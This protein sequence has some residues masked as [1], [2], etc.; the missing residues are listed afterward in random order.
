M[1]SITMDHPSTLFI[2]ILY[3]QFLGSAT[4]A[5]SGIVH[6]W[7][8]WINIAASTGCRSAYTRKGRTVSIVAQFNVFICCWGLFTFVLTVMLETSFLY[9][10]LKIGCGKYKYC[11]VCYTVPVKPLSLLH[12]RLSQSLNTVFTMWSHHRRGKCHLHMEKKHNKK[13]RLQ[14][15]V[16][17]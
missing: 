9:P 13:K 12:M 10:K 11:P 7:W 4:I 6:R 15:N 2:D 17:F 5:R 1:Y 16:F 3:L 8:I 14:S